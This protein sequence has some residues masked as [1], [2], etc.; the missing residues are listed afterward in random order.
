MLIL[1]VRDEIILLTFSTIMLMLYSWCSVKNR[2]V[3]L[4]FSSLVPLVDLREVP[5]GGGG[6]SPTPHPLP[7]RPTEAVVPRHQDISFHNEKQVKCSRIPPRYII[8]CP[9]QYWKIVSSVFSARN[10]VCVKTCTLG[11]SFAILSKC[12]SP[13]LFSKR[14]LID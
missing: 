5:V 10:K 11:A 9:P 3:L 8:L 6:Y 1:E 14:S 13:S 12:M 2:Q 7:S 4:R